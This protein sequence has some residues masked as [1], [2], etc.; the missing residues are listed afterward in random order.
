MGDTADGKAIREEA[1]ARAREATSSMAESLEAMI[2]DSQTG[3][4]EAH[5]GLRRLD[6]AQGPIVRRH[7]R[8]VRR[9]AA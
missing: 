7:R 9:W 2:A 6:S 1:A 3:R 8:A 4:R 5:P